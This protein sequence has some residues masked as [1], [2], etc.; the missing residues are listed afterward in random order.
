M[1]LNNR[2]LEITRFAEQKFQNH[3]NLINERLKGKDIPEFLVI[4]KDA[5]I[6]QI[7]TLTL[8]ISEYE[9]LWGSNQSFPEISS[10]FDLSSNLI[11]SRISQGI[12]QDELAQKIGIDVQSIEDLESSNFEFA[13]LEV[14]QRIIE[15]L[16]IKL[17]PD[18]FIPE[19]NI[20]YKDFF[21]KIHNI[22]LDHY[23]LYLNILP[24]KIVSYLESVKKNDLINYIGLVT[25]GYI[26]R[27][28]SLK[29]IEFLTDEIINLPVSKIGSVRY[30]IRKNADLQYTKA[31]TFYAHYI[32][33]ITLQAFPILPLKIIE[34]PFEL[35]N[36]IISSF[37]EI[38]LINALKY[39]WRCGIPAI[40]LND[41]GAFQGALIKNEGRY[42]IILKSQ[43]KSEARYIFDL[44]HELF[45][46]IQQKDDERNQFM[47]LEEYGVINSSDTKGL[48]EEEEANLFAAAV[49]LGKPP[50]KIIKKCLDMANNDL[51]RLKKSV[52][53][54]A[55][56]ENL[57]V[58][59][60][61][62]CVA[63]KISQ[64]GYNWW[65]S[66]E[67][68]QFKKDNTQQIIN[69]I[70]FHYLDF[71]LLS[72]PDQEILIK[73]LAYSE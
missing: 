58:D 53:D 37:G 28:I 68:L 42:L 70:S 69:E 66:A 43:S 62:N 36:E 48:E 39:L 40:S 34:H 2:E 26:C 49:L 27:I 38:N 35:R 24:S 15:I 7:K 55:K 25:I 6:E 63:Y 16:N 19:N 8:Q 11:N 52:V 3:L 47:E 45:H 1:I 57:P 10:Y 64:H 44:F 32:A 59:I 23:K 12:T 13:S 61:A 4:E 21:K 50:N 73:A 60:L 14:I 5:I 29:P 30:K 67:S 9:E 41:S 71:T 54:I 20:T 56:Q 31:Y 17:S 72:Y 46:I 65:G 18:L 51:S 22:G 33:L